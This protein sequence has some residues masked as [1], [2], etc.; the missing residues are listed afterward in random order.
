VEATREIRA[1]YPP[2]RVIA[3]TMYHDEHMVDAMIQAGAHGYVLK[4]ARS[5]ELLQAIRTVAAGGAALDPNVTS[6]MLA[7]Y[8][9][10]TGGPL[11]A[12]YGALPGRAMEVLRLVAAGESNR[13]IAEA[14][15]LSEQTVKNLLS[16]IY[17]RLGVNNRAEAAAVALRRG[18]IKGDT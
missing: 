10:M 11:S 2:A 15:R 9:Q 13:S 3:L 17:R 7:H 14:L 5:A 12:P 8:R 18:L 6:D 16:T 1:S 4:E